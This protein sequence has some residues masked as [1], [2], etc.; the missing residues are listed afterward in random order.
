LACTISQQISAVSEPIKIFSSTSE[1]R[2]SIF[3]IIIYGWVKSL[4]HW[5]KVSFKS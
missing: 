2:K 4:E 1:A 5:Q 3:W